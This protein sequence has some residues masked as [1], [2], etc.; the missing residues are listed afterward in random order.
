MSAKK[1]NITKSKTA[2]TKAGRKSTSKKASSLDKRKVERL[3]S[4]AERINAPLPPL[5]VIERQLINDI[6]VPQKQTN[7]SAL[8]FTLRLTDILATSVVI[9]VGVWSGYI[10]TNNNEIMAPIAV[11]FLGSI[12]FVS[13]LFAV[14]AHRFTPR[15]S[16]T[17]HIKKIALATFAALGVWLTTA[18]IAK[19]STF[20]PDALAWA[21]IYAAATLFGL[22][23]LYFYFVQRLHKRSALAPTIVLLGA[24]ET[25]RRLIEENAKT[26]ELNI[27]AIFDERLEKA[28]AD[29]HGVPIVGK[30][31]DLLDWDE[32]PYVNRIVIT[33]PSM[34]VD[35]KLNF[36]E[37]VRKLPNNIAFVIDEFENLNHIQQ[38]LSQ[39][40][41]ISLSDVAGKAKSGRYSAF[42]RA[43]DV[44]ISV[45]ALTLGAPVLALI[46][47]LIKMDSP[48]PVI[49]TQERHGLNNRVIRV[50]KFRSL[51]IESEDKKAAQQVT[52]NDN[53][54]TKIGRFIRKTSL[55]E[56]PQLWNVLKGE[57]SLVGPRPHAIG[58]RTGEIESYKLVEEYAHRHQV[59]PGMTGWAQIHGS[60]G[61]L[62]NADD[63]ARRVELDIDYIER[64]STMLDL[65]IMFKTLPC[66]LG[67]SEN[68]R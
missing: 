54:V 46:A 56:L 24:T 42:K 50:H 48:G 10:G 18:I 20:L 52:A 40:T 11:G 36:F 14:Q 27:L 6:K 5:P 64:S 29:I 43:G 51:R 32:L 31:Q 68:I 33:L 4:F 28:P 7:G 25:A 21:G 57:M 34:A 45:T 44:I 26:H 15:E 58:M 9:I 63:V 59:K 30:I 60:R 35:R 23:T 22:H 13:L 19:P 39:I 3:D 47:L 65:I 61:P 8:R 2:A 12:I 37:Q 17:I 62:H 55:D 67:D 53:R 41:Q 38:R 49:F 66:L 16:F 1:Q